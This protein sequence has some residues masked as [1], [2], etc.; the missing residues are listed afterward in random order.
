MLSFFFLLPL[1]MGCASIQP[2]KSS[3]GLHAGVKGEKP[4]PDVQEA[5]FDARMDIL[6]RKIQELQ[7]RLEAIEHNRDVAAYR[8]SAASPLGMEGSSPSAQT[9]SSP[10]VP[11][12]GEFDQV[13][14]LLD[15]Q[16]F[17]EAV[18]QLQK[19]FQQEKNPLYLFHL[20]EAHFQM[21]EYA[22]AILEFEELKTKFPKFE[23]LPEAYLKQC[24]AFLKLGKP[25]D[26]V[27][28]YQQLIDDFPQSEEAKVAKNKL[29]ALQH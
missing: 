23:K 2:I 25:A 19:M 17:E 8:Q 3:G 10:E 24:E 22:Q 29:A 26:A 16:R 21:T 7:G 18:S 1:M 6:E 11:G 13:K 20:A 28:F 5:D 14:L 15:E 4:N 27:L 9:A 12:G